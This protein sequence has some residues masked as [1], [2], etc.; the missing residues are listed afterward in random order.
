MRDANT[1]TQIPSRGYPPIYDDPTIRILTNLNSMQHAIWSEPNVLHIIMYNGECILDG[2][3]SDIAIAVEALLSTAHAGAAHARVY[4]PTVVAN[5]KIDSNRSPYILAVKGIPAEVGATLTQWRIFSNPNATFRILPPPSYTPTHIFLGAI[6]NLRAAD[7]A[8][9]R[10]ACANFIRRTLTNDQVTRSFITANANLPARLPPATRY[11]NLV[12]SVRVSHIGIRA[13]LDTDTS[14]LRPIWRVYVASP[15]DDIAVI[16]ELIRLF[17]RLIFFDTELSTGKIIDNF[18][19]KGCKAVDHPSG[20]CP[21]PDIPGWHGPKKAA[22][23]SPHPQDFVPIT[24][25]QGGG[26]RKGKKG[27]KV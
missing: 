17:R 16:T 24:P 10:T 8:G 20:L 11:N 18:S 9:D 12:N 13:K 4:T 7:N 5:G 21:F 2:N 15:S 26:Q 25:K 1:L 22:W 3:A 23:S 6:A 14:R 19:C 27:Q